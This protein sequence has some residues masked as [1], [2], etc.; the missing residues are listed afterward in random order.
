[1][2]IYWSQLTLWKLIQNKQ[3]LFVCDCKTQPIKTQMTDEC[4]HR[5]GIS[6]EPAETKGSEQHEQNKN[7]KLVLPLWLVKRGVPRQLSQCN[8]IIIF[9][10][11]EHNSGVIKN[12]HAL[13]G[14]T[15][16]YRY[17]CVILI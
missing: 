1:M 14:Q 6:D 15:P 7:E 4:N 16:M 5:P 11:F 17:I 8:Y 13:H 9:F 3:W 12:P 2:I 10:V